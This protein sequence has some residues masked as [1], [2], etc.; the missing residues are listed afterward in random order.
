MAFCK[1]CGAP[2][3][4]SDIFC[5]ECG[6]K[7]LQEN[8][9]PHCGAL[10]K[11]GDF[12]C[13]NC[14]GKVSNIEDGN[15]KETKRRLNIRYFL[16]ILLVLLVC[17]VIGCFV[18][19]YLP[20]ENEPQPIELD[21]DTNSITEQEI[22]AKK[23]FIEEFYKELERTKYQDGDYIRKHITSNVKKLLQEAYS[24]DCDNNDCLAVW[25][26]AYEGGC[27]TGD[28]ISLNIAEEN[29]NDF[30][31]KIKY[32]YVDYKVLLTV[33]KDGDIYKIDGLKEYGFIFK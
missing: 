9:C 7:I 1:H 24:F 31:I 4:E 8:I 16:Y 33:I 20:K 23:A 22:Q 10:I 18:R 26:F 28:F 19:I 17:V 6:K 5:P 12:F 32:E 29:E 21:E 15:T 27:D 11:E 3:K 14:G 30:L 13:R 2:I 25:L